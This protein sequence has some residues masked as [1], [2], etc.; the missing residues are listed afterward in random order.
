MKTKEKIIAVLVLIFYTLM[1][2]TSCSI[3]KPYHYP[4]Q[5]VVIITYTIK[6][7]NG[8]L[9]T[10]K[11]IYLKYKEMQILERDSLKNIGDTALIKKIY[12]IYGD[13]Y[14]IMHDHETK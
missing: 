8:T 2:F 4:E 9:Y 3:I 5:C 14:R 7:N 12:G 6:Q 11:P 13:E 10:V 1:L